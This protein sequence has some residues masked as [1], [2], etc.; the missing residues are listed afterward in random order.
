M[1]GL[2]SRVLAR[3]A[4]F[5]LR[6]SQNCHFELLSF[7]LGPKTKFFPS[8]KN[9][10]HLLSKQNLKPLAR[11]AEEKN[12]GPRGRGKILASE[13]PKLPEKKVAKNGK[14]I[15]G[16]IFWDQFCSWSPPPGRFR[17]KDATSRARV[18]A[19]L[20][21][22]VCLCGGGWGENTHTCPTW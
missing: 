22:S 21:V 19:R 4:E 6:G 13:C 11:N 10:S 18:R 20:H 12:F 1:N 5:F 8:F 9:F 17:K 2:G 3:S 7:F 16:P 14:E 15:F